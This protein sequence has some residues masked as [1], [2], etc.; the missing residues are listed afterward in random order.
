MR[1]N[2]GAERSGGSLSVVVEEKER[3]KERWGKWR[4]LTY[5]KELEG[6]GGGEEL[7]CEPTPNPSSF[8][9]C[10]IWAARE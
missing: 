9:G 3:L 10:L 6:E 2:G 4:I 5:K 7:N 1:G 8:P